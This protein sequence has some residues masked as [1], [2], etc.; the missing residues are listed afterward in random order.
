M[1]GV[2]TGIRSSAG[3]R[4]LLAT[5]VVALLA[6]A[7]GRGQA[8]AAASWSRSDVRA[9]TQPVAS[10]SRLVMYGA[11][12]G[13]F[14]LVVLDAVS[15]RTKWVRPA[16]NSH[17]TP[18]VAPE[19]P[20]VDGRVIYLREGVE[21]GSAFV[22]AIDVKSGREVWRSDEGV[23]TSWPWVCRERPLAVCTTGI[24]ATSGLD[25][26]VIELDA[27][28]GQARGFVPSL[29][30]ALGLEL[31]DDG[32]RNPERLVAVTGGSKVRWRRTL[33]SVFPFAGATSDGGW[34]FQLLRPKGLFV[35][36]VWGSP[37]SETSTSAVIDLSKVMTA[38]FASK[39][40]RVRWRDAGSSYVCGV[41]PCAGGA[42]HSTDDAR[43]DEGPEVGVRLR[44]SGKATLSYSGRAAPVLS[45]DAHGSLEG[46]SPTTGGT[47]WTVDVAPTILFD[48][49]DTGVPQVADATIAIRAAG[50]LLALDLRTGRSKAIERGSQAWCLRSI[51]YENA[52]AYSLPNGKT[53]HTY[54]GQQGIEPCSADGAPRPAPSG[55]PVF[56]ANL[57][58]RIGETGF[59][60]D[61]RGLHS[62]PVR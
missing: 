12:S 50:G 53:D 58:A 31:F 15:G 26:G 10:G 49:F 19:I 43:S 14:K 42:R 57:G 38:G 30:R 48:T 34:N 22:A 44:L 21:P 3:A 11:V 23:F 36:S 6:M 5:L 56:V 8:A 13:L 25:V 41:L 47:R 9:V 4:A 20:I 28:S 32:E 59:W 16:T 33:R 55:V 45:K 24:T 35:G 46:F 60:M 37:E 62:A 1:T 29:V 40:G 52:R 39:D 51:E 7:S 61:R 18:G 54:I 17:V 2:I 27:T